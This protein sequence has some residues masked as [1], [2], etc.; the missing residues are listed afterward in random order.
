MCAAHHA[1]GVGFWIVSVKHDLLEHVAHGGC[2]ACG[3]GVATSGEGGFGEGC[4]CYSR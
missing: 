4:H 3:E 2:R 1:V